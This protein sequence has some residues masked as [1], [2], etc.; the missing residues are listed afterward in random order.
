MIVTLGAASLGL[1]LIGD[2]MPATA[3]IIFPVAAFCAVGFV[4]ALMGPTEKL[5]PLKT[6]PRRTAPVLWS[7]VLYISKAILFFGSISALL[8]FVFRA[9]R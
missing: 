4:L 5:F 3:S 2:A 7:W 9:F 8:Y 1:G 6:F